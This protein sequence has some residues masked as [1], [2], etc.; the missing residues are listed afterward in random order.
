MMQSRIIG[1]RATNDSITA[2]YEQMIDAIEKKAELTIKPEQALR[3]IKVMEAAFES[4]EKS[5]AIKTN[6]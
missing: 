1:I 4:S 3:V 2:V 5:E 6:I